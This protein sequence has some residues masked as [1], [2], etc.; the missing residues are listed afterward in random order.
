MSGPFLVLFQVF[1]RSEECF[2]MKNGHWMI[3]FP[4]A[5]CHSPPLRLTRHA[6][7][8]TRRRP[9]VAGVEWPRA[10]IGGERSLFGGEKER[11]TPGGRVFFLFLVFVFWYPWSHASC[12]FLLCFI[13]NNLFW[14]WLYYPIFFF[15]IRL[16]CIV[17]AIC[18][19]DEQV[20]GVSSSFQWFCKCEHLS[21]GQ[22]ISGSEHGIFWTLQA[23]TNQPCGL[24][25]NPQFERLEDVLGGKLARNMV[26]EKKN[27]NSFLQLATG[28]ELDD[29]LGPHPKE[30][31]VVD[32]GLSFEGSKHTSIG[33]FCAWDKPKPIFNFSLAKNTLLT[34]FFFF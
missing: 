13:G 3:S 20:G 15:G 23:L 33:R 29:F 34:L 19:F 17:W 32:T 11:G 27:N 21:H 6:H 2:W 7:R 30:L 14:L 18:F 1:H 24:Q 4:Q 8:A 25:C 31:L 26:L 12:F 16:V 5:S 9:R 22:A 10:G 28:C